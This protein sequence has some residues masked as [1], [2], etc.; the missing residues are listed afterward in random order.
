ML[1]M[2]GG[3]N[4]FLSTITYGSVFYRG[5]VNQGEGCVMVYDVMGG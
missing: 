3:G 1:V 5:V 2:G 4:A